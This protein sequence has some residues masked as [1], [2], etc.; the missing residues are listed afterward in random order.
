MH[1]PPGPPSP[2]PVF[3]LPPRHIEYVEGRFSAEVARKST[4][5]G[6]NAATSATRTHRMPFF[7]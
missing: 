7:C 1:K 5:G 3:M 2:F 6:E 4:A